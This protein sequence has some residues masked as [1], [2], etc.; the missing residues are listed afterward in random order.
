MGF[1][2]FFHF[3]NL[4]MRGLDNKKVVLGG[5]LVKKKN[6]FSISLYN[7][8]PDQIFVSLFVFLQKRVKKMMRLL[9]NTLV[10]F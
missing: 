1:F 9:D 4:F 6:F 3:L 7:G 8:S 10:L 5:F 2:G